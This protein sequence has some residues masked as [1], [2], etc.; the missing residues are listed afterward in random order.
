MLV[1]YPNRMYIP[2]ANNPVEKTYPDGD[3]LSNA[4]ECAMG[5]NPCHPETGMGRVWSRYSAGL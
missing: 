2:A 4:E 5:T 3:N 1:N